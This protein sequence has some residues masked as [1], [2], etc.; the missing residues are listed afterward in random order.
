MLP[1]ARTA[2]GALTDRVERGVRPPADA[3]YPRPSG[4]LLDTCAL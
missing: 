1:C 4:D 2:F 3:T